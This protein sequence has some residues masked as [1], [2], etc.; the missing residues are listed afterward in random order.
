MASFMEDGDAKA[1]PLPR[2]EQEKMLAARAEQAQSEIDIARRTIDQWEPVL[3]SC[4]AGLE[5]LDMKTPSKSPT[6]AYS[7]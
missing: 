3:R 1:S 5:A 2:D 7:S 4:K 6:G